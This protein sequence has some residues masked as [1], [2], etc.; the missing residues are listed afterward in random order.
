VPAKAAKTNAVR[1]LEGLGLPFGILEAPVDESDLSAEKAA[2]DLGLP[3]ETVYKTLVA[4]GDRTGFLKAMLPAGR[5]LDLKALSEASGNR[6][7]SMLPV[8]DL[9]A[10]TGYVR[11][12]CSP[13]GGKLRCP[14]FVLD[15]AL[16]QDSV[17]FNA[18]RRGL[19]LMMKPGDLIQATGAVPCAISPAEDGKGR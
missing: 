6:S 18:G 8:K 13:L 5:R 2:R 11:G 9:L 7:V 17:V 19:F 15:E 1:L 4:R 3:E 12:G 14:V 16:L 10:V